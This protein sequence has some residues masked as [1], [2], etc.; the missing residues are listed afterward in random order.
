MDGFNDE[1]TVA[2]RATAA[3]M[4]AGFR[5]SGR[6]MVCSIVGKVTAVSRSGGWAAIRRQGA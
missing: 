2:T 6:A 4:I 5:M 3:A 1:Q